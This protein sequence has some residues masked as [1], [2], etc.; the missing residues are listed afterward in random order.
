MISAEEHVGDEWAEWFRMTPSE[1]WEESQS[2]WATYLTLGGSLDT[3]PD[4]QSPFF[5]ADEWR[6]LSAHGR[7]SVRVVRRGGV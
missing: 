1:R 3:E 2:L 6:R 5:D 4:P 7:P